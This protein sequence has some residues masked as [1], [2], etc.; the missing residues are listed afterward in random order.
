MCMPGIG[1]GRIMDRLRRE[2]LT[3]FQQN[4]LVKV[5]EIPKGETRSYKQVA[6]M[7][8]YPNAYRAVGTAMK[9]NPMA[10]VIPCHRVIKSSGEPGEYSGRGGRTEKVRMLKKERAL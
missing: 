5:M 4:V 6:V 3:Q 10:P 2:G 1:K 9:K 8:G 7:A